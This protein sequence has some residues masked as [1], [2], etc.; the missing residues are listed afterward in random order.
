MGLVALKSS[1]T[2][3]PGSMPSTAVIPSLPLLASVAPITLEP[4]PST[5]KPDRSVSELRAETSAWLE[6]L[7]EHVDVAL[8]NAMS[9][10]ERRWDVF[11]SV[12]LVPVPLRAAG[13]DLRDAWRTWLEL[14]PRAALEALWTIEATL[15][16]ARTFERR[17][18]ALVRARI[19]S[20]TLRRSDDA[21]QDLLLVSGRPFIDLAAALQEVSRAWRP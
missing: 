11:D 1:L 2:Q 20:S 12:P 5:A 3:L 18:A 6:R 9:D 10:V 19:S 17:L 16:L 15:A 4:T 21:G 8:A 13:I 7:S 14:S